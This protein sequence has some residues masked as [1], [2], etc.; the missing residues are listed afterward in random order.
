MIFC[1]YQSLQSQLS[2]LLMLERQNNWIATRPT[3][4]H[5]PTK[6]ILRSICSSK[7][8]PKVSHR[9]VIVFDAGPVPNLLCASFLSLAWCICIHRIHRISLESASN[10]SVHVVCNILLFVQLGE[11]LV[12]H[13]VAAVDSLAVLLFVGISF[14]STFFK[15]IF[16]TERHFVHSWSHVV[17]IFLDFMPS[18]GLCLLYVQIWTLR[19]VR[20]TNWKTTTKY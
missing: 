10:C 16:P 18:S 9:A 8:R 3:L 12:Q 20:V 11:L 14:V 4:L 2:C 7:P 15:G 6:R 17:T 1:S 19:A 5:Y 13:H